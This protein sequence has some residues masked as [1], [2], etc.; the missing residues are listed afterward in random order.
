MSGPMDPEPFTALAGMV[1][2]CL[3]DGFMAG[4]DWT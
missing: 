3:R 4:W 2:R 1:A